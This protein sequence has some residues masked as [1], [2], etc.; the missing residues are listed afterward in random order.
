M[1]EQLT[2]KLPVRAALGREDFFVSESNAHAVA[3]IEDWAR[4]PQGKLALTGPAGA[5]KSHLAQVWASESGALVIPAAQLDT[6]SPRALAP[7]AHVVIEDAEAI[8]GRRPGEEALFHLHNHVLAGGGRL[9]LTARSAPARWPLVLPDLASRLGATALTT[10]AAPDDALLA[11]VLVKLFDDRQLAVP[12]GVIEYLLRRIDRSFAAAQQIVA[13]I[14][15]R[16][17]AQ[18]RPVTRAL[19]AEVLDSAAAAAP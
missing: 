16:A 12:A 15:Q 14:D 5:G 1:K 18:K 17:L 3:M 13:R 7:G 6:D 9:M 4:W 8:A 10:L 11:A 2:L 19:A